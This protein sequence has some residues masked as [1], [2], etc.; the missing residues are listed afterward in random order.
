MIEQG[1]LDDMKS[2]EQLN[3][4]VNVGKLVERVRWP[5][6]STYFSLKVLTPCQDGPSYISLLITFLGK[7][8][9]VDTV[10]YLLALLDEALLRTFGSHDSLITFRS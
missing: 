2:F 5:P 4:P 3:G 7:I 10:Q 6:Q 1:Q 9:R 8:V